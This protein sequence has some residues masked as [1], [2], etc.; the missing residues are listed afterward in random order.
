MRF[1][2][3]LVVVLLH[4]CKP[5]AVLNVVAPHA[6][7]IIS[8]D[9][10]Y[11]SGQRHSLDIYVPKRPPPSAP[12]I[13]FFYGGGWE[14]GQKE[15]YRFVGT[16]L[17]SQ[18]WIVVIPD[19]R[20]YPEV[21]FPAFVHDA[22]AAVA[23]AHANAARFGGDPHRLF[24]IGHSA[25]AQIAALLAL[26]GQYLAAA[27]LSPREDICGV[28][29][30]AGPYDFLPLNDE[31]KSIFGSS[32][33]WPQSQPMNYASPNAP[34]MLLL[35]GQWDETVDPANTRRFAARLRDAGAFAEDALYPGISHTAIIASIAA[36]LAFLAPSRETI[37]RFIKAGGAC[38]ARRRYTI[39][40]SQCGFFCA[41]SN[42]LHA[43]V[44]NRSAVSV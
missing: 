21:Q 43:S 9:I 29:G 22:A 24:L 42:T 41:S 23:W 4:A 8:R 5:F 28:I 12:V 44:T 3:F 33:A 10:A 39:G 32:E 40:S 17:A 20:L 14:T 38:R 26:D 1:L 11:A 30:L 13:V 35:A 7:I 27:R 18:G 2:V 16:A 25:G 37:A 6:D 15:T 31:Q 19:Y 36:P 34:P